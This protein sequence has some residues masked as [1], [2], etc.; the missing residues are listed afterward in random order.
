MSDYVRQHAVSNR[1][2]S[3]GSWVILSPVEQSIKRKIESIGTPLKDWNIK[4]YR[5]ILTGYNEAF[6]IDRKKK[7]ELISADPKS[8]EII[9]PILRGRDIKRYGFDFADQYIIATFP[10]KNYNIDDYPAV[11]EYLLSFGIERLEQS[12]KQY[13]IN[14]E[15][16][17]SRKKTNNKWFETQDS[18]SYWDD[19]SKQKIV[20]GEISDKPKFAIDENGDYYVEATSFYMT[21]DMLFYLLHY[22]NSS[23]S[24]FYFS[25]LG[26]TTGV[27]TIRWK[28]F[29]LEELPIPKPDMLS[30]ETL[31]KLMGTLNENEADKLILS[32]YPFTSEELSSILEV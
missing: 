26:T 2:D 25:K 4:I 9:R 6:I 21:G 1:F 31:K 30:P 7:D 12:G 32:I 24:K 13:T 11:K 22:L 28:K 29:K 14:G 15:I 8:A 18:I 20:W 23:L 5:G 27:G 17:K 3:S 19:F 10:S 16:V